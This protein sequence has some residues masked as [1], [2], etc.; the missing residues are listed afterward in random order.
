MLPRFK[1]EEGDSKEERGL[2]YVITVKP[3]DRG[4]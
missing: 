1:R 3:A 2:I 4:D